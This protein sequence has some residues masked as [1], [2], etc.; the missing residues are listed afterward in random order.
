MTGTGIPWVP[1]P[2][3]EKE[4]NLTGKSDIEVKQLYNT[5][6]Q[7]GTID[8]AKNLK[9]VKDELEKRKVN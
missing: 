5:I 8:D 2:W 1:V 9:L 4:Y 6:L 7:N 3:G